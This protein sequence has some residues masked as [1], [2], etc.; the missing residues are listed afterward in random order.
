MYSHYGKFGEK[1]RYKEENK[2]H[3]NENCLQFGV[4][5]YYLLK[6]LGIIFNIL[7]L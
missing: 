6:M 2:K 7:L 3:F 1:K 4:L 5:L